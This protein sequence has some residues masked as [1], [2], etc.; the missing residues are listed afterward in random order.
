MEARPPACEGDAL[1]RNLTVRNGHEHSQS[2]ESASELQ[3]VFDKL[4]TSL[5]MKYEVVEL[6]AGFVGIGALLAVPAL[7]LAQVWRPLP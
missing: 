2:A 4:P 7:L 1:R 5:I 3:S 6:S